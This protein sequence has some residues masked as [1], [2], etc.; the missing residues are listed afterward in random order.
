MVMAMGPGGPMYTIDDGQRVLRKGV[1]RLNNEGGFEGQIR[2]DK[3][4]EAAAGLDSGTVEK[5]MKNLQDKGSEV[6][7]PTAFLSSALRKEGGGRGGMAMG[8]GSGPMYSVD[9]VQR[10]LRKG[11]ARL[12]NE[13]GFEGRIRYDKVAEAAAAAGSNTATVE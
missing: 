3:V 7:D 9:D 11:V 13:G 2:Y 8:P 1:A 6:K 4:A 5:A 10:V 12:N